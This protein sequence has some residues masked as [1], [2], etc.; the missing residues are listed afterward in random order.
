MSQAIDVVLVDDHPLLRMGVS[1]YIAQAADFRLAAQLADGNSLR[2]WLK[3][4]NRADVV[5]L[6]R[7]LPDVDGL[8]LVAEIKASGAKVIM[9]TIADTD[10][11]ISQAIS[12]GVDGY[13][14]KT[15]EP[16]QVI[17]A[18]RSVC[19]GQG[20]FPLDVMQRMAQGGFNQSAL[21]ALTARELEIVELVKRGM[22]NK[23]IAWELKL[24]ENTVRNHLRNIMEKLGLQN[25]VQVA[26]LAMKAEPKRR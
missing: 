11:E 15:S 3:A 7:S 2:E 23:V 8:D 21:S 12:A 19:E 4:G 20:S 10:E 1:N 9:L 24:S 6:D 13:V 17:A 16:D 5:L 25:R 26:T 22:S 18:I 14:V